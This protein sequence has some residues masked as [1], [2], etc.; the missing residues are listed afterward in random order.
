MGARFFLAFPPTLELLILAHSFLLPPKS[1][2]TSPDPQHAPSQVVSKLID[3]AFQDGCDYFY[4]IND[5]SLITTSKWAETFTEILRN[6][7]L[8]ENVGVTGP[9][10]TN[11]PRIL[12]HAFVHRHV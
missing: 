4:Q 2:E 10:D 5:D 12:T 1:I 6:N 3:Q 7:P 8:G 9:T 11:N